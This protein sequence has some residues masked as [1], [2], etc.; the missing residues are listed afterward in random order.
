MRWIPAFFV[1]A[2]ALL[3]PWRLRVMFVNG[4]AWINQG[5]Y[6]AVKMILNFM[7]KRVKANGEGT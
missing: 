3:L 4:L 2:F 6:Y 1:C 7:L 5:L